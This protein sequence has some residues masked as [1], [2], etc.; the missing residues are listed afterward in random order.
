MRKQR[1]RIDLAAL[2]LGAKEYRRA[3]FA[4]GASLVGD[5]GYV[6]RTLAENVI[7][8]VDVLAASDAEGEPT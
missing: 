1:N 5:P 7:F 8:L 2:K 4:R 3:A 6:E